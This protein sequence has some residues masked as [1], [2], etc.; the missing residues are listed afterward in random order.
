MPTPPSTNSPLPDHLTPAPNP[1]PGSSPRR[2]V[3]LTL[4]MHL[5]PLSAFTP[6]KDI[7]YHPLF[8]G[9]LFPWVWRVWS[10]RFTRAGHYFTIA[11]LFFVAFGSISLDQQFYVPLT[12]AIGLW[13][14]AYLGMWLGRPSVALTA[15]YAHRAQ[16]GETLQV[17][18]DVQALGRR[19]IGLSVLPDRL[20][21]EVDAASEDGAALPSLAPGETA[22][23][24]LALFCRKRGVFG[25][26]GFRVETALP[27]G[28][29]VAQRVFSERRTLL[30]APRFSPLP[31]LDVPRGRRTQ[32]GGTASAFQ[33][34]DSFEFIGSRE[35][36]EG[37]PV[38]S[39]DWRATARLS[40]PVV[41]EYREEFLQRVAVLLDTHTPMPP[42]LPPPPSFE[43]AVSLTAALCDFMVRSEFALDVLA[44]GPILHSLGGLNA[45]ERVMD[46]LAAVEANT[47]QRGVSF[48]DLDRDLSARL[49]QITLIVCVFQDWDTA[50]QEFAERLRDSGAGLKIVV[51]RDTPCT[52]PPGDLPVLTSAQIDGGVSEI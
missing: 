46:L 14:V 25:L 36:R 49:G 11:T 33:L 13:V 42:G 8:Q 31:R 6:T 9:L 37:D 47:R 39:I 15:H 16:A 52:L 50:R 51:V 17:E 19:G 24:R 20:P 7:R 40:R 27:L 45:G 3:A 4:D 26:R 43:S 32:P 30:V 34:G 44:D 5:P 1:F 48:A 12:Y 10:Q 29:M 28:L 35:Y 38:R 22:R 18:I 23:V 21:P 41:R 2:L